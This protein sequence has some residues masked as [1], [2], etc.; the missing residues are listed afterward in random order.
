MHVY[1][2]NYE[3][4]EGDHEMVD[5][6]VVK[7]EN[8]IVAY[9]GAERVN[10]MSL[11]VYF[12]DDYGDKFHDMN[13]THNL[14]RMAEAAN[15][16]YPLWRPEEIGI[17]KAKDNLQNLVSGLS[18]LLSEPDKFKEFSPYN[19][20]G[21][22]EGLCEFVLEYILTIHKYPDAIIKACR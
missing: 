10:N 19:G 2:Y 18:L 8:A 16:Y 11:D 21:T 5:S 22:Y 12:E 3:Y 6:G 4:W 7:G 17:V 1:F 9:A 14:N 20:W 15:L 13:I